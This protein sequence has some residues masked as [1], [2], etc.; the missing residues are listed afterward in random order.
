[1][2]ELG[3]TMWMELASPPLPLADLKWIS[4]ILAVLWTSF[5]YIIVKRLERVGHCGS[6]LRT[7]V[8]CHEESEQAGFFQVS[9]PPGPR[10]SIE[11]G[12]PEMLCDC[13]THVEL[14]E[15]LPNSYS[16]K[17]GTTVDVAPT[18]PY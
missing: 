14:S 16:A 10:T 2:G 15:V 9:T 18:P 6:C 8:V 5:F 13:E 11:A 1:M 7:Q 12:L 3:L 17:E 4:L